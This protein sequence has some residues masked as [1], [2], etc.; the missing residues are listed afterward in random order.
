[1]RVIARA[2]R[3]EGGAVLVL[4]ALGLVFFIL[5]MLAL[6]VDLGR[7]VGVK[8][9]MVNAADAAAL[10]A[11]QQCAL[12]NGSVAAQSA[13]LETAELNG[14]Q[15]QVS[16]QFVP[17]GAC[18]PGD[19]P[20]AGQ[21]FVTV[22]YGTL[23]DYFVAPVLGFDNINVTASATALW[24]VPGIVPITV[25]VVPLQDCNTEDPVPGEPCD[26]TYPKD[27]LQNPRWG[28]LDLEL[29]GDASA[30]FCPVP[31]SEVVDIIHE[32]GWPEPET[33]AWDCVD[34]GAQFNSWDELAG[35]T[36]WFPVID[37]EQS[38]GYTIPGHSTPCTGADIPALQAEN[39]DCQITTAWVV[40]FVQLK[41]NAV[42]KHGSTIELVTEVV[43][44]PKSSAG[45][46]I[47]LVD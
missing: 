26:I 13:A 15:T 29:W 18:P 27:T 9:D 21:K 47:R 19:P 42:E 44:P 10:A 30:S 8:R 39:R 11:A 4:V 40:D 5:G 2:R 34:N 28:I 1:M 17:A 22:R 33:P 20:S 6:T 41:V 36:W 32:G 12:G 23:V 3:E 43:P 7:A 24:T 14:A 37:V 16:L 35:G 31:N 46:D 45:I 38:V 25:N